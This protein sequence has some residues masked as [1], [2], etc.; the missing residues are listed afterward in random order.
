[1]NPVPEPTFNDTSPS[2]AGQPGR[3]IF[4]GGGGT[5][6]PKKESNP[7]EKGLRWIGQVFRT[8]REQ[9]Q[10]TT[11]HYPLQLITGLGAGAF[12]GGVALRIWRSNAYARKQTIFGKWR[13]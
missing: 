4:V 8:A 10:Y 13:P 12:V 7:V 3:P 5:E 9:V 6:I 1:M 2:F 11:E